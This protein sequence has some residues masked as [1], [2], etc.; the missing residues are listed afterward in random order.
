[1]K[2]SYLQFPSSNWKNAKQ[3]KTKI[4]QR[5]RAWINR[6]ENVCIVLQLLMQAMYNIYTLPI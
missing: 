1:M 2:D 4:L 6:K 3:T 5:M